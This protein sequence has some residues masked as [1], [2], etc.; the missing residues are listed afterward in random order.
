MKTMFALLTTLTLLACETKPLTAEQRR[1][2][3]ERYARMGDALTE[4][5]DGIATARKPKKSAPTTTTCYVNN[6]GSELY[7][8]QCQDQ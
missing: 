5:A 6:V 2:R 1:A 3:A 7:A 8:T 4:G